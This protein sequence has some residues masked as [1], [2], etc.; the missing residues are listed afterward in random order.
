MATGRMPFDGQS[1]PEL[2]GRMLAGAPT[3]PR[4]FVPDLPESFAAAVL[5]AL[6]PAPAD[7]FASARAMQR[8]LA[9]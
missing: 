2:L 4:L 7:R 1:M 8:A 5:R 9:G 3:D 6:R